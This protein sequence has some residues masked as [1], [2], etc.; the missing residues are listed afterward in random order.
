MYNVYMGFS[1][2]VNQGIPVVK[3]ENKGLDTDIVRHKKWK[4]PVKFPS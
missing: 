3:S 4:C 2:C 1:S